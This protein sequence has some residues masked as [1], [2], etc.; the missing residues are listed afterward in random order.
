MTDKTYKFL[1]LLVAIFWG[2]GFVASQYALDAGWQPF[3]ILSLRGF[4][5]GG[6]LLLISLKNKIPW[7]TNQKLWFI[8]IIGGLLMFLGF[9]L[10][11]YGQKATSVSMASIFVGIYVLLTPIIAS[12][13]KKNYL[14]LKLFI[15][16]SIAFVAILIACYSGGALV[17][18]WGEFLL[19]LS[20]LLFAS[21]FLVIES[22][23]SYKI[24]FV[25]S[26]VQ[27]LVMG[28]AA[29]IMSFISGENYHLHTEA[30]GSILY[31]AIVCSGATLVLQSY[32]Q[33]KVNSTMAS[34]IVSS[35]SI[36]GVLGAVLIYGD[37][38]SWNI[39]LGCCLMFLAI[40]MMDIKFQKIKD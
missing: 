35:E 10:Q 1:L 24:A 16:C 19:L 25:V 28:F 32:A 15:A 26:G 8:L 14:T 40:I 13:F 11:L 6:I 7:Y 5:A 12:F 20:S 30:L 4:I 27:L 34:L 38:F 17:F 29:M 18:G 36:F 2:S 21:H 33:E 9:A 39:A 37:Q 31:L 22:L 23:S 3:T